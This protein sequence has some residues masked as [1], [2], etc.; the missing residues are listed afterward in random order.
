MNTSIKAASAAI[1][2][3]LIVTPSCTKE[4][5]CFPDY[6]DCPG[7][8]TGEEEEP[9]YSC[10]N[11][12]EQPF[13]WC[14]D[15]ITDIERQAVFNVLHN[16]L[17]WGT[18]DLDLWDPYRECSTVL[19]EYECL[20]GVLALP[21]TC[22]VC[23]TEPGTPAFDAPGLLGPVG[24]QEIGTGIGVIRT[25]PADGWYD[26]LMQEAADPAL[27]G[28]VVCQKAQANGVRTGVECLCT[29]DSQCPQ[30]LGE[31][32]CEGGVCLYVQHPDAGSQLEP[33][34]EMYGLSQWFDGLT[35]SGNT[36]TLTSTL[37]ANL[38]VLITW[39][40]D[41]VAWS[42]NPTSGY[43]VIDSLDADSLPYQLGV[44]QGDVIVS[45]DGQA[46]SAEAVNDAS[47][48]LLRSNSVPIVFTHRTLTL[49]M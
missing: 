45:V 34:P 31:G 13:S 9:D 4:Q 24:A 49:T 25:F 22:A 26:T 11:N 29:S 35:C 8:E 40:D 46:P 1:L 23:W 18:T 3:A 21:K 10:F 48:S 37:I 30:R 6:Q 39:W 19:L 42:V 47:D 38:H 20:R 36:C 5:I 28:N 41:D 44:R 33:G 27:G 7:E 43:V 32:I 2:L 12:G 16:S 14:V 15:G 17:P